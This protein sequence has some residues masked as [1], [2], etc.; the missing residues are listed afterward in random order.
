MRLQAFVLIILSSAFIN[1]NSSL[2]F[3]ASAPAAEPSKTTKQ[4]STN[5]PKVDPADHNTK[6][7]S[8]HQAVEPK[9]I[10]LKRKDAEPEKHTEKR[11]W[12]LRDVDIRSV[13]NE[14]SQETGKNF[15]IDPRVQGKITIIS[16]E[17][18]SAK[19]IYQVFLSILQINGF[20]AVPSGK[21]T[22]IIPSLYARELNTPIA[23]S[24]N[25][26]IGEDVVVRVMPVKNNSAEQLVPVLRPLMPISAQISVYA[27]SNT[28]I[29]A[30]HAD[31]VSRIVELVKKVD[32]ANTNQIAMIRL[33]HAIAADLVKEI[34]ALKGVNGPN[35]PVIQ[36]SADDR[37]NS[38]L[39]GGTAQQRLQ[40]RAL[41]AQLDQNGHGGNTG[42]TQVIYLH[43]LK[44]K[45]IL[46]VLVGIAKASVGGNVGSSS[47]GGD[48]GGQSQED[49]ATLSDNNSSS[50]TA[51]NTAGSNSPGGGSSSD[52]Q[53]E[54]LLGNAGKSNGQRN[55]RAE[56]VSIGSGRNRVEIEA[57]P[58]TNSV[59]ITAPASLVRNMR[60]VIDRLDIRPA[61]VLVEAAIVEVDESKL[62]ELGI[63]W[64]TNQ[65][66]TD[67]LTSIAGDTTFNLTG[68]F[69]AGVIH[70]GD[71]RGLVQV[72]AK[73]TNTNILSTP[74]VLVMDNQPADIR[75]GQRLPYQEGSYSTASAGT[76]S[77]P[78]S[79][80]SY[81]FVG[82]ELRVT[83]QVNEGNAVR[84]NIAQGNASL[85][86]GSN[87]NSQPITNESRIT[88][89]V[90][91]D[92]G[93]ILVLGGLISNELDETIHKIPILSE[94][95]VAG[96]FFQNKSH[97]YSKRNLMVFLHPVILHSKT[98]NIFITGSKYDFIRDR[99]LM[100]Q[101]RS[102]ENSFAVTPGVLPEMRPKLLAKLPAP[103]ID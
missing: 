24:A 64:G 32:V 22:K 39:V 33:K 90:L 81:K 70:N 96:R 38:I 56:S 82:L 80:F 34:A 88:T 52:G 4:S 37:T 17:P 10:E 55:Q 35:M 30:G 26:G 97:N 15:V 5:G 74:T 16:A 71:F 41:V 9:P 42:N 48:T 84:L 85:A 51:N 79:T 77:T 53:G 18:L 60:A 57:E 36:L 103:F 1:F 44:A 99:Q 65:S 63:M 27:P 40:I 95:P 54:S 47:N 67:T 29:I 8:T 62:R 91:V 3:A 72:L 50:S 49:N 87:S 43:Y 98:D 2:A 83:P 11:V 73:D 68:G 93:E 14:V 102:V 66:S 59:V 21:V 31:N 61:Q 100:A 101:S 78:Y 23:N 6:T 20:A 28:L 89:S 58:V 75:V 13:I 7:S 76:L 69:G 25:P 12:N 19:E 94:I 46:P 45:E 86:E 92:N